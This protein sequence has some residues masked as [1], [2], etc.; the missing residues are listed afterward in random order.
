LSG[1][2]VVNGYFAANYSFRKLSQKERPPKQ[3][4]LYLE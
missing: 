2:L 1:W 3:P 4:V